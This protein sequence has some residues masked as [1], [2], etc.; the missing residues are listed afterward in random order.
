MIYNQSLY[1]CEDFKYSKSRMLSTTALASIEN[2]AAHNSS[3]LK[4]E[5]VEKL[6]NGTLDYIS[7]FSPE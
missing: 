5:E 1:K 4:K 6:M 7:K 2:N 3:E